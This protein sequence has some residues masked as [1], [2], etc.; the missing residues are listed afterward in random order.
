MKT[1]TFITSNHCVYC[2]KAKNLLKRI[3]IFKPEYC[4]DHLIT[5]DIAEAQEKNLAYEK[6]PCFYLG[7]ERVLEGYVTIDNL[8]QILEASRNDETLSFTCEE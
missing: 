7:D 4:L 5:I 6:L 2:K 1:I 3:K 8:I